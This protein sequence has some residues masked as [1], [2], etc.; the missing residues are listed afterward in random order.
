MY[1]ATAVLWLFFVDFE[2][3]HDLEG[4]PS[5]TAFP[6][7]NSKRNVPDVCMRST[8]LWNI[9]STCNTRTGRTSWTHNVIC[10]TS[11]HCWTSK[12]CLMNIY[13]TSADHLRSI[14]NIARVCWASR[15]FPKHPNNCLLNVRAARWTSQKSKFT[16]ITFMKICYE[17][18][19]SKHVKRP[20][21]VYWTSWHWRTSHVRSTS[22]TCRLN[23][24]SNFYTYAIIIWWTFRQIWNLSLEHSN[25]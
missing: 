5:S 25:R 20:N 22:Q 17:P 14:L 21:V 18:W 3:P 16:F 4:S 23:I 1:Y 8:F 13:K 19:T 11:I 12:Y 2:K 6:S 10:R 9:V 7:L 24:D 15:V